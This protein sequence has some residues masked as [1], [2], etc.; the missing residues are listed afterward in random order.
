MGLVLGITGE[1]RAGKDEFAKILF[2]LIGLFPSMALTRYAIF[3]Y[4]DMIAKC[5]DELDIDKSRKNMQLFSPIIEAAYGAGV[6]SRAMTRK[7]L[8]AGLDLAVIVG[9]R[10]PSDLAEL[11]KVGGTLVYVTANERIRFERARA[12]SE[13]LDEAGMTWEKFMEQEN[14]PT[15][16]HIP[17]IG[18][19]A[20]FRLE[21]NGTMA[22]FREQV[23]KFAV[24]Y[25]PGWEQK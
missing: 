8:L 19:Q 7:V 12:S 1:K 21:N 10:W 14:A 17:A 24:G 18:A 16:I 20:D 25:L 3:R 11:R 23:Y 2:D 15:E 5:L 13:K 22:E 9:V 4:S 6:F